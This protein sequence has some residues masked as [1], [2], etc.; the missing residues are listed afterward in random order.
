MSPA[1]LSKLANTVL[2]IKVQIDG[3][4][5]DTIRENI[6]GRLNFIIFKTYLFEI[7]LDN[8]GLYD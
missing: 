1:L 5:K 7:K 2:R 6:E 4:K 3:G 8:L